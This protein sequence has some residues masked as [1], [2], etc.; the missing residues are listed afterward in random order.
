[1][2]RTTVISILIIGFLVFACLENVTAQT[3][4][5]NAVDS[6]I[7][8][9]EST[10]YGNID[11]STLYVEKALKLATDIGYTEGR[12]RA[13]KHLGLIRYYEVRFTNALELF[14]ESLA[15]Y[16]EID[17]KEGQCD[18][19]NLIAI[20]Y[21]DQEKSDEAMDIYKQILDIVPKNDF[22]RLTRTYNNM[23]VTMKELGDYEA[24]Y[25][26]YRKAFN[27]VQGRNRLEAES[28]YSNNIGITLTELQ[29]NDSTLWFLEHGL[30]LALLTKNKHRISDSYRALGDYYHW[31]KAYDVALDYYHKAYDLVN[32]INIIYEIS[33]TAG[34]LS[35][36]YAAKNKFDEAYKYLSIQKALN[37][38]IEQRKVASYITRI[39]ME[40]AFQKER[41]D[42]QALITKTRL[43]RNI[44][45]IVALAI[46]IIL[47]LVWY[48][49]RQKKKAFSLLESHTYQLANQKEEMQHQ[50]EKLQELNALKDKLFSIISHDLRS[51]LVSLMSLMKLSKDRNLS[52]QEFQELISEM[53]DNVSYTSIMVDNLLS[54]ASSQQKGLTVK[55]EKFSAYDLIDE[56]VQNAHLQANRKNIQIN[57]EVS[58]ESLVFADQ[59]LLRV[60][61]RNLLSNAIKFSFENSHIHIRTIEENQLVRIHIQDHGKG[62]KQQDIQKL[63]TPSIDSTPGTSN[64]KGTGLGLLLCKEFVELNNGNISVES[65][66]GEGSTFIVSLPKA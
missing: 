33:N 21:S 25:T 49:F 17:N 34:G 28:Q 66:E 55:P 62:I 38:S 23:G 58:P 53:I 52:Q 10:I 44:Y 4:G 2:V 8:R 14:L 30:N 19:L 63:F 32:Q 39:E 1:M 40:K 12:A 11:T 48:G 18:A 29:R 6:L 20:V 31:Q 46:L 15:L 47:S 50:A 37:D 43:T 36:A 24:S 64:E 56:Q 41:D 35:K 27:L 22:S 16:Q 9:S 45:I 61:F 51:P 5:F 7:E 60:V 65:T 59:D 3:S 42:N 57:N 54:W 26:Y 13:L